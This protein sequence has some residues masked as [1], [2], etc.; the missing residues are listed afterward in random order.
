MSKEGGD[1]PARPAAVEKQTKLESSDVQQARN[2]SGQNIAATE[3][4]RTNASDGSLRDRGKFIAE[5]EESIQIMG[6]GGRIASR[7]SRLAE[8]DLA[9]NDPAAKSIDIRELLAKPDKE[10][11]ALIEQ[12]GQAADMPAGPQRDAEIARVQQLADQTYGRGK[13][14]NIEHDS[15]LE[16]ASQKIQI[17]GKFYDRNQIIASTDLQSDVATDAT[18]ATVETD[19]TKIL[20]KPVDQSSA[21]IKSGLDYN[22]QNIALS[23]KLV[24]FVNSA[25]ARLLDPAGRQAYFQ[26]MLDETLGVGEGLNI[27]KEELK[28]SV[29]VSAQKAWTALCDGSVANFMAKPNAINEPLFKT[30]CSCLDTMSGDPNA[31]NNVLTVMG[32]ELQAAS[33][34][35]SRMSPHERGVQDG[36]AMF[37]FINPEGSTEAG[38]LALK[39]AD[40]VATHVDAKVMEIAAQAIKSAQELAGTSVEAAQQT[41]QMLLDYLN[42]KGLN[43]PQFKLAGIPDGYFNGMT[44]SEPLRASDTINAMSKTDDLGGGK[45]LIDRGVDATGKALSF[46]EESGIELGEV[47]LR[48]DKL[49][50]QPAFPRG[51]DVHVV[52]GENLPACTKTIDRVIFKDG[53][54]EGQKSIDLTA[55]S[56]VD[57]RQLES[58]LK[59]YVSGMQQYKGQPRARVSFQMQEYEIEQKVLHIGIRDGSMTPQQRE[60][61]EK[62]GMQIQR[63][64]EALPVYKAPLKL[65]VTVVK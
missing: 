3:G 53:I 61:F 47:R 63:Y 16:S 12:F 42:S 41:K 2:A 48:P 7:Q 36:K 45:S 46:S 26:G 43:G 19:K 23:Q 8:S 9:A 24:A 52:L 31:V 60:I 62:I 51:N 35:Y 15:N 25:Q 54:A 22:T 18:S 13:F 32:R 10:A 30:I 6:A 37:N 21:M 50:D 34:K 39:V 14:A 40:K 27:A 33:D 28:S 57:S 17:G 11:K 55:D 1:T 29:S 44:P 49:W 58:K 4:S 20:A 5:Q 64:N 65:K 56:Y 38:D 59:S